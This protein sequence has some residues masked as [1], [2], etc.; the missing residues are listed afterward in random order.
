MTYTIE[1]FDR[2]QRTRTVNLETVHP[3]KLIPFLLKAKLGKRFDKVKR[4]I[5]TEKSI[6]ETEK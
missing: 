6:E 3:E 5:P 4:I 1:Y 2:D